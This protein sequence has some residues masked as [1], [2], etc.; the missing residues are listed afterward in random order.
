MFATACIGPE[1]DRLVGALAHP[2]EFQQYQG[3]LAVT[4][5]QP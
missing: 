5:Q 2:I 4:L 1:A 3:G